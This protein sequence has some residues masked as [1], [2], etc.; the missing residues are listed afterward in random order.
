MARKTGIESHIPASLV[1]REER[2]DRS[3][4]A[5]ETIPEVGPSSPRH[6]AALRRDVIFAG[7]LNRSGISPVSHKV[8]LCRIDRVKLSLSHTGHS[9]EL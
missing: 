1:R 8:S 3:A 6:R 5:Q 7:R 2:R 4:F 9:E